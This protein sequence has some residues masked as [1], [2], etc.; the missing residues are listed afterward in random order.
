MIIDCFSQLVCFSFVQIHRK[1]ANMRSF[2]TK[3]G[4]RFPAAGKAAGNARRRSELLI[5]M[6]YYIHPSVSVL[7]Y[8][9]TTVEMLS[10]GS[11]SRA[12]FP[13]WNISG[14]LIDTGYQIILARDPMGSQGSSMMGSDSYSFTNSAGR[15][16]LFTTT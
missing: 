7:A 12:F 4:M 9:I 2:I 11:I 14:I 15:Y 16:F 13:H 6:R 10:A 1:K 5:F 8:F 3:N